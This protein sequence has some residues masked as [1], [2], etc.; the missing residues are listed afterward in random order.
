MHSVCIIISGIILILVASAQRLSAAEEW[1]YRTDDIEKWCDVS[2][3]CCGKKQSPVDLNRRS[4]ERYVPEFEY[5]KEY[6]TAPKSMVMINSGHSVVITIPGK[7]QPRIRYGG[8]RGQYIFN[9]LHFHWGN[10]SN[11]GSEHTVNRMRYPME[12]HLVH[13]SA[14]FSSLEAAVESKEKDALAVLG[15]FITTGYQR[16]QRR[17]TRIASQLDEIKY[18]EQSTEI[19]PFPLVDIL[20]SH[21][22]GFYRYFGSLTT[23]DCNEVVVWTI[24]ADEV[25]VPWNLLAEIRAIYSTGENET[26]EERLVDNFRPTQPLNGR[27]VYRL[28]PDSRQG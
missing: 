27:T 25:R 2:K 14:R 18:K 12:A 6:R 10:D 1:S 21:T 28:Y 7:Y 15:I 4:P 23:P 19:D 5:S 20:P 8:L 11:R 16:Y 22:D 3:T 9:N 13:Y 26:P 24:F 17:F